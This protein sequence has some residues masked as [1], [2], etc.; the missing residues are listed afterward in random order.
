MARKSTTSTRKSTT[1]I[2]VANPS[3]DGL[4]VSDLRIRLEFL[5]RD[6]EKLIKQIEKKRTELNNLLDRIREIGVEVAQRTAPIMQ[7]LLDLDT[8]IHTIF[9]EIFKGRKLGKQS[10]KSIEKIYYTLQISGLISPTGH[11]YQDADESDQSEDDENWD[12]DQQEFD[13]FFGS[14]S[15]SPFN[16][17][18]EPPTIDRDEQKKIRQLFLRLA[19][20][21]HPDKVQQD[22]DRNYYTEVM[23]EINQAYQAGD[24]AKLLA[25][26]KQH[27]MGEIIDRDNEDDLTR[28][29][30][31]IEQENEFLNSQFANLK[32]ELRDVKNT[33]QGSVV[34]EYK[35]L[36]KNGL[37]PI[38][39]MVAE[40][41][42]QIETIAEIHQF[43]ADFRDKKITIKDFMQGPA[44]FQQIHQVSPEEILR[45]L[46]SQF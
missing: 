4:A 1:K 31:R 9:A 19:D 46:F 38:G 20:V 26:E 34:A 24:L 41:E 14:G 28:R 8:K 6:N 43:V 3:S 40:T 21:F 29:C 30:A 37:D 2:K 42:S 23:K 36:T 39:E 7:Q 10:R 18:P 25:I 15:R 22:A 44:I 16:S 32:Q 13:D 12:W 5:E 33:E 11:L 45:E 17:E 27:Q 35:K